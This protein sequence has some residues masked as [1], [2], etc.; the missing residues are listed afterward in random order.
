MA[1]ILK[2][3]PSFQQVR[4][5]KQAKYSNSR[6]ILFLDDLQ[7]AWPNAKADS[8]LNHKKPQY[9]AGFMATDFRERK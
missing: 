8:E 7:S 4:L 3:H 5:F 9:Q 6:K 2:N 1:V